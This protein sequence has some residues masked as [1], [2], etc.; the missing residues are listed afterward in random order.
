[1]TSYSYDVNAKLTLVTQGS[2]SRSFTYDPAG[3]LRSETTPEK[4]TVTYSDY[5]SLGNLLSE[6]QPGGLVLART[7]DFAG[8]LTVLSSNE[9]GSRTYLANTFDSSLGRLTSRTGT[10][11]ALVPSNT[12]TDSF[13][14]DS[15][16]GRLASRTTTVSGGSN[17]ST[18]QSW[19]YNGLGLLAHHY[20][21][22]PS[23]ASPFVVSYGYDAGLPVTQYANGIP[24]VTG[25]G[26][27]PS[28]A[29]S[30]YTT[31]I[32]TGKNVTTTV[33]LDASLLPRPSQIYATAQATGLR[34][35]D[36]QSYA[37]DGAG[38]IKTIGADTS[39]S[40]TT[41]PHPKADTPPPLPSESRS[42]TG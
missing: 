36:T 1:V 12:V 27:Q 31:G 20:H 2:Q 23:G 4:G 9:G 11:Y 26:Y 35:F 14:Y 40:C 37:Y 41:R 15:A 33:L 19:K 3:F 38:N 42:R 25:V 39:P 5:G 6:T 17:L 7:Y 28:G 13:A 21:P 18:V 24:M 16:T 22:R 10:N 29:V 34:P 8:R 30:S 32:N